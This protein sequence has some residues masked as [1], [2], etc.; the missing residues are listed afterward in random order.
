[1]NLLPIRPLIKY[2]KIFSYQYQAL[3]CLIMINYHYPAQ[4]YP[5]QHE[6]F[7]LNESMVQ[8]WSTYP[9]GVTGTGSG[10][11]I[12]KNLVATDCHVFA[13]A[14]GVNV[15]KYFQTYS[16]I[17]VYADWKHD[18]CIL[19]FDNLPLPAVKMRPSKNLSYEEAVFSLTFPN[20]NPV[21]LPSYGNVKALY[22]F[23]GGNII[24]MS[25]AFTVGSSGGAL[26]DLNFNLIGI[27]TFKSPGRREGY[28]YCLPTEWIVALLNQ[29]SQE[30]LISSSAPFWSLPDHEKPYFMQ[31]VLPLQNKDWKA[32]QD[33]S[34]LWISKEEGN[35]DA[36][37]YL[38]L[39]YSK[40]EKLTEAKIYFKKALKLNVNHFDSLVEL[41]E[42]AVIEK[43]NNEF[44]EALGQLSK[45]DPDRAA[46][47]LKNQGEA[48]NGAP[49]EIRTP[50]HL[51][52]SQVLYPA[53]LRA[54]LPKEIWR[55]RR[56]SN[57]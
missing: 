25:A 11:V 31:V 5:A 28:Y 17:A 34:K 19:K 30:N 52:R 6:L 49:E 15:V 38:A 56:D 35:A 14:E 45:I 13:D 40:A 10:V 8:V 46:Y 22:P 7:G 18:L 50:D 4:A 23:E 12:Q 9:N 41:I 43:N 33:I 29:P 37:Y 32:M 2:M 55:A 54:Q 44:M 48:V 24:R 16:P 36:W 20:D 26:F 27:T 3:L 51:V 42:I 1:M 39:S 57:S 21:P 47:I 53:E